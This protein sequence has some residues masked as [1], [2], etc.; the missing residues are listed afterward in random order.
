MEPA[1]TSLFVS[2]AHA[3]SDRVHPLVNALIAAGYIVWWDTLIEGG[4]TIARRIEDKLDSA[5]AVVVVWSAKSIRSDW[6]RDEAARAR[7]RKRLVPVTF[8]GSEAP[9]GFGQYHVVDLS[10]WNR[11]PDAAEFVRLK[12]GIEAAA[13]HEAPATLAAT[14]ARFGVSRRAALFTGGAVVV[15]AAVAGF[16]AF[17]PWG[18]GT[19]SR[20]V[21]VLPFANLSGDATQDYFSEG[22]SE[23]IRATLVRFSGLDVAAATSSNT[24]RGQSEDA[25][26]IARS[27]GVGFLLDGSVRKEGENV[28]IDAT[29]TDGSTGF[30]NWTQRFDRKLED[31]FALQSEIA[32]AVAS[33]ILARVVPS[34]DLPGG[35]RV[36]AAYDAFLRGR[37][38]FNSDAGESSDRAALAQFEEA[39]ALDPR[40]AD[41]HAAR[42]RS[43][44]AI[45]SLYSEA[46]QIV[47][48]YGEAVKAA[49]QAVAIAPELAN[50]Q[51]ALGFALLNGFLD[52]KGA[53]SAY[54]QAYALG[55]GDADILLMFAYFASKAGRDDE[56][57]RVIA[58]A[59]KLDPLNPRVFRA[60]SLIR[61][62]AGQYDEAIASANRALAMNPQLSAAH[63]QIAVAQLELGKPADARAAYL[64]EPLASMRLAGLAIAERRLENA[65]AAERAMAQLI[66]ELGDAAI[67]QQ[68]QVLAQ[69]GM[70][71]EALTA[72]E[73]AYVVR[74]GGMTSINADPLFAPL[75]GEA[76]FTRL[77]VQMGLD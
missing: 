68:A 25:K 6:V 37:A 31:I 60:E 9:L 65:V 22:L 5:D 44:A 17:K 14:A 53:R 40:F 24:F 45:A 2:Y 64:S 1:A 72:L 49:R 61:I 43:L 4:A 46:G 67:Y 75:R 8:D 77:L 39:V 7:D 11:R 62:S 70:V 51:L 26:T 55:S 57:L 27:L 41:A 47:E 30:A 56:A 29:L 36:V 74:D 52:F 12:H 3:D 54:D 13:G 35:T 32:D 76:R 20:A 21:A 10:R 33:A 18:G 50:G 28:R 42:S 16:V 19:S 69:W 38:L 73:K 34:G 71:V 66:S 15:T 58:R 63:A 59:E 48:T 23:E